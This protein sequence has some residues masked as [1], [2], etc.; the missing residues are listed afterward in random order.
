MVWHELEVCQN[1][2]YKY[3]VT[4]PAE[5]CGCTLED[6]CET[7]KSYYN[8]RAVPGALPPPASTGCR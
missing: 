2:E 7:L 4:K 6:P 1:E 3:G 5:G 8:H